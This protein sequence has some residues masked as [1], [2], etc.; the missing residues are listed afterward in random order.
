MMKFPFAYALLF[1]LPLAVI[2]A[3]A[4]EKPKNKGGTDWSLTL[5][6]SDD[7]GP[8]FGSE[9]LGFLEFAPELA[10]RGSKAS[11]TVGSCVGERT[12]DEHWFISLDQVENAA[13]ILQAL[14]QKPDLQSQLNPFLR[15]ENSLVFSSTANPQIPAR[16]ANQDAMLLLSVDRSH[17]V[18]GQDEDLQS[19]LLGLIEKFVLTASARGEGLHLEVTA[20]SKVGFPEMAEFEA[21]LAQLVESASDKVGLT[22]TDLKVQNMGRDLKITT[23]LGKVGRGRLLDYLRKELESDF[24]LLESLI[25]PQ[26]KPQPKE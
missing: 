6:L 5:S 2:S 18:A 17:V 4:D 12:A 8:T 21:V 7:S 14:Q 9:L 22:F 3:K 16:E 13:D 10:P 15:N 1:L 26:S 11:L 24:E 20:R 23:K 25:E 19:T